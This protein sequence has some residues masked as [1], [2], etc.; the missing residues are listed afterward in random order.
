MHLCHMI[1]KVFLSFFI[2]SVLLVACKRA[3]TT[4]GVIFERKHLH[5]NKLQLKYRYQ[6]ADTK[7][8]D[9]VTINNQVI[10][11]DTVTL[12]FDPKNPSRTLVDLKK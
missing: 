12:T 7:Y 3:Q 2:S 5:N 10:K 9:S 8:I 4:S 6:F 11:S 1:S